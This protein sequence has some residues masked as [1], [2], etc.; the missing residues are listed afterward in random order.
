MKSWI[1]AVKQCY[2]IN[3]GGSVNEN[4][5]TLSF[6]IFENDAKQI[7]AGKDWA[8]YSWN[9]NGADY[10]FSA[11]RGEKALPDELQDKLE[12]VFD[13]L[14]GQGGEAILYAARYVVI[15]DMHGLEVCGETPLD[16]VD[17]VFYGLYLS[18]NEDGFYFT[19][20]GSSEPE[21]VFDELTGASRY[22]YRKPAPATILKGKSSDPFFSAIR[23]LAAEILPDKQIDWNIFNAT[24]NVENGKFNGS[25][26]IVVLYAGKPQ[27][28]KCEEI[29][30]EKDFSEA[31]TAFLEKLPSVYDISGFTV[32]NFKDGRYGLTYYPADEGSLEEESHDHD[33]EHEH[34]EYNAEEAA[35]LQKEA[36]EKIWGPSAKGNKDYEDLDNV[37]HQLIS[38]I[39]KSFQDDWR[40][41]MGLITAYNE[42]ISLTTFSSAGGRFQKIDIKNELEHGSTEKINELSPVLELHYPGWNAFAFSFHRD[43]KSGVDIQ[44]IKDEAFNFDVFIDAEDDE[45]IYEEDEYLLPIADFFHEELNDEMA[46]VS[47]VTFKIALGEDGLFVIEP[48]TAGTSKGV[49][50]VKSFGKYLPKISS[51]SEDIFEDYEECNTISITIFPGRKF[52]FYLEFTEPVQI[53]NRQNLP[54][55]LETEGLELYAEALA[56]FLRDELM[57]IIYEVEVETSL[58]RGASKI[59]GSP[60]LPKDMEYPTTYDETFFDFIAQINL[61]EIAPFDKEN[62]LPNSGVLSFFFNK[63]TTECRVLYFKDE[64][65]EMKSLNA[66]EDGE[67]IDEYLPARLRFIPSVSLPVMP[68]DITESFFNS[69]TDTEK[70]LNITDR[71]DKVKIFGYADDAYTDMEK[72][73]EKPVKLLLQVP[74]VSECDMEWG[75][76]AGTLYFWISEDDLKE[77]KFD[78]CMC[79]IHPDEKGF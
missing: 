4:S 3:D 18:D 26:S 31:I 71:A 69:E 43:E 76:A 17:T 37:L 9:V 52:G 6:G 55:I 10:L 36:E 40:Y 79:I 49:T 47:Y 75:D 23:A 41:G 56:P 61:E 32:T 8:A 74:S 22:F 58:V 53:I 27:V 62:K 12:E 72:A 7:L 57:A 21:I 64:N 30:D 50:L 2:G 24:F 66:K 29:Y 44:S 33:H 13:R 5:H 60:D 73:F 77:L 46:C 11:G 28:Y 42:F 20:F 35:L 14:L 54:S 34:G 68:Y 16:G 63:K 39:P 48:A 70:Y 1:N 25:P 15:D 78:K 59:G 38:Y 67:I 65:L 45:E 51:I 19:G